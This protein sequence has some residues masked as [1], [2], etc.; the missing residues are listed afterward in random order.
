MAIT[1]QGKITPADV[2]KAIFRNYAKF[3]F[4]I[5]A[6]LI[7]LAVLWMVYSVIKFPYSEG[8]TFFWAALILITSMDLW[9]PF[10]YARRTNQKGSFYRSPIQGSADEN[11]ITVENGERKIEYVWSAFT[12]YKIFNE[13]VLLYRGKKGMNIFTL[14]LFASEQDWQNFKNLMEA[15]ISKDI[16]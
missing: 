5:S 2:R 3:R 14:D 16:K 12:R 13:M 8:E 11:G 7:G 4:W 6:V 9:L 10:L 1:Y 15:K